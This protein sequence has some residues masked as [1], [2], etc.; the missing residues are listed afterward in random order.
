MI[1]LTNQNF[2]KEVLQSNIPVL[3]DFWAIWCQPCSIL[4]PILE[5]LEEEFKERVIFAQA[6]LD[7]IPFTAQKLGIE[8][9]PTVVLFR[10]GKLV[11]G[12]V[13]VKPESMIKNWLNEVLKKEKG[14][15]EEKKEEREKQ[16]S[17]KEKIKRL[18]EWY[19]EYAKENGFQLNSDQKIVKRLIKGLLANEKKYGERYCP[20]RRV[21]GN[22]EEDS[23]KI[24]PCKWHKEEIE[25]N[26]HCFCGLFV[27]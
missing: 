10:K 14:K 2:E 12:F 18:I 17:E 15:K 21:V 6:N 23:V 11:A 4:S 27:R 26:G 7:A 1:E 24:C 13:G 19:R 25:R 5:D 3:V 20:C 16:D 8:R 9:I 22:K